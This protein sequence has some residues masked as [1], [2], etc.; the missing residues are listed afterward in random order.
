MKGGLVMALFAL[1]EL[2]VQDAFDSLESI[3]FFLVP[4]EELGSVYSRP[5][6]ELAA[7]DADWVLV[8]EPGRPGGG[9]VTARGALGALRMCAHGKSAHCAVNYAKGASAI[10]ELALKVP[11]LEALSDPEIGSVVNVGV[12]QGGAARQV[13]PPEAQIHIDVRARSQAQ[14]DALL[15]Q[16]R[17]IAADQRVA[18]VDTELL[19]GLTRPA[20]TAE[21]N[22]ALGQAALGFAVDLGIEMFEVP[23]TGG[24]SDG[25]FSAAM[26]IPTLDGLGPVCQNICA[27]GESIEIASLA[28]RGAVFCALIQQLKLNK[29]N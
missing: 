25:N 5:A 9:I 23:P 29:G 18:G 2:L 22:R 7:Q 8:L 24:G 15:S 14:A 27:R 19:G 26:G 10:H 6:I 4:D 20:F 28:E 12:F 21:H 13:V 1:Q 3:T 16:I 17:S 11:Q